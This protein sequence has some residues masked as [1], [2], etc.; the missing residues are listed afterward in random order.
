MSE[1]NSYILWKIGVF[2]DYVWKIFNCGMQENLIDPNVETHKQTFFRCLTI[3]CFACIRQSLN[4]LLSW[5]LRSKASYIRPKTPTSAHTGISLWMMLEN[6]L[7]IAFQSP[8]LV[9]RQA[10]NEIDLEAHLE[11]AYDHIELYDGRDAKAPSLGRFCGTKKPPPITSSSNKLFIRFFS[12]NSVQK[13]GFEASHTLSLHPP[14][15]PVLY[16][17]FS[18]LCHLPPVFAFLLLHRLLY[19]SF[20]LTPSVLLFSFQGIFSCVSQGSKDKG[21]RICVCFIS[22]YI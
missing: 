10:F 12:D 9:S 8:H 11:C 21:F 14:P 18:L 17:L 5:V 4:S 13:K 16:F 7:I 1:V 15:S 6:V 3:R 22:N 20:L 19:S 2:V